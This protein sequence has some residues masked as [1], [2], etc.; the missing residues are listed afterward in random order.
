MTTLSVF[1]TAGQS[2]GELEIKSDWLEREKGEQAVHDVVVAHLAAQRSGTASTKTRGQIRA[3][4]DKP[5]RQK[6]TGRA[7]SGRRSSPIWTGG[8]VVFGPSYR[9]YR[10]KVNKKVRCLAA[11]RAFAERI[12]EEAVTVLDG[13]SLDA[14]KTREIVGILDTLKVDETVLIVVDGADDNLRLAARNLPWAKVVTAATVNV[15]EL[16]RY[17][18]IVLTRDAVISF[19]ERISSDGIAAAAEVE[20]EAAPAEAVE[21]APAEE[22]VEAVPVEEAVEA[23]PVEE[24]PVD[25]AV[26]AAPEEEEEVDAPVEAEVEAPAE[27]DAPADAEEA[28]AEAEAAADAA[29]EPAADEDGDEPKAE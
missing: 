6:G 10:K 7:R 25:E 22:A 3:S 1:N 17:H 8:G 23:A 9:S 28:P 11:R 5:W 15:Y 20:A 21:A 16:L 27:A 14:P 13:L 24:A 12:D 2:V 19:G 26:E 4:N 29:A 18:T